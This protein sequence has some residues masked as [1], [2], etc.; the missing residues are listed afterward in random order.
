M[1]CQSCKKYQHIYSKKKCILNQCFP[2]LLPPRT[3]SISGKLRR[4][5]FLLINKN[6][7][8]TQKQLKKEKKSLGPW[9]T[10][11]KPTDHRLGNTVLKRRN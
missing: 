8:N 3:T 5:F 11:D 10:Y 4:P 6:I 1:S 2:T 7:Q 9:T